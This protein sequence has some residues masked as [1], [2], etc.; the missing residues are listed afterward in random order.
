MKNQNPFKYFE[1]A[2]DYEL[3]FVEKEKSRGRKIVGIYCEYTPREIIL[4]AGAIPVCLCG[5]SNSTVAAAEKILP[6]NLCPL[7]KSSFGYFI[8]DSCPFMTMADLIVA[9]TTCD[10]K[11]KMYEIMGQRKHV[12]VLELTQKSDSAS[13]LKHWTDE[14][15]KFRKTLETEFKVK[16]TDAD[17]RRAIKLMNK[18][19]SLLK[20]AFN[21][22]MR[23]PSVVTGLELALIRFRVAGFERHLDMLEKFI[24]AVEKRGKSR[25]MAGKPRVLL[26][27]C[28]TG[29]GSGKVIEIIEECGGVLV[30]QEA[31]SGIKSVYEMTD[32]DGDPIEAIARR[33]FHLPC[34][35]LTPN[36]GRIE[37]IAKL[38][39]DFKPDAVI[40]LIWQ[41]C[42]TY[43]VESHIVGEF[44]KNKLKL[45]F[46]KVE[47]DYSPSDRE[48]LKVRINA[49][50]EIA[51]S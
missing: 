20:K 29:E 40:D 9:E 35:C 27:G 32:E 23:N 13:A 28:P 47:T 24:E 19:R 26:T 11:K 25:K 10:G 39:E 37:L 21:L 33:H 48:Q 42:H 51:R 45:P 46:L 38:A 2:I 49:L 16:I 36:R 43:N 7:I 4:A 44:V 14:L 1:N 34:S 22:G 12:E 30:V 31:C 3:E 41:A 18:E 5:T 6:S 15:R 8:T 17:L 50:L